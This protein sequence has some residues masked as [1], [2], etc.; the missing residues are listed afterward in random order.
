MPMSD[1]DDLRRRAVELL[2]AMPEDGREIGD[3]IH[4]AVELAREQLTAE[5]YWAEHEHEAAAGLLAT[6]QASE[7]IRIVTAEDFAAIEEPG[8]DPVLGEPGEAVFTEDSDAMLYGDGGASKT[9]LALDFG[10]HL[11]AGDDWLGIAIPE[12]RRVLVVENEGPRPLFRDKTRRKLAKWQGSEFGGRLLVWETPWARFRFPRADEIATKVGEAEVDVL[13]VGPLT[14]V[15]MD[16]HGTLQEVRDFMRTVA[17]FR[18]STGRRLTVLLIHHESKLGKVSGAWE[19]AGDTLLH[20]TVRTHGQ[21]ILEFQKCRWSSEWHKRKLELDWID[22]ESFEVVEDRDLR[23]EVAAWLLDHP[24]STPREIANKR[25]I[26]LADGPE[27]EIGGVGAREQLVRD[28]LEA[29]QDRFQMRTGD[30]AKAVGRSASAKVW[31]VKDET[32]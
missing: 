20:A 10:C 28:E 22:G 26:E 29:D 6:E 23:T 27:I 13:I 2:E 5:D 17:E 15:G 32:P 18:R 12:P 14:G 30:E 7:E 31:E 4:E 16:E 1:P 19:A 8:A 3:R 25:K 9:S 24:H 21:T 11:A